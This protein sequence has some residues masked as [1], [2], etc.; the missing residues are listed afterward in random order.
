MTHED[1]LPRQIKVEAYSGYKA[2]E[3][4]LYFVL[5]N[6]R[7]EVRE[8][9]DR[10]YGEEHDYFKILA[11]DDKIYLVCRNRTSDLWTLEKTMEKKDYCG[12]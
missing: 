2:D 8:I 11:D 4:P 12:A 9:I 1:S 10:W 7:L 3:R 5:D 6:L